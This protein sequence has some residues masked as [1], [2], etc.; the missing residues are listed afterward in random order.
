MQTVIV[1]G[2][3][4]FIGSH[5]LS[6]LQKNYKVF[7]IDKAVGLN[8]LSPAIE[9]CF[10]RL[11]PYAI[12]HLAAESHVDTSIE[13][14]LDCATTNI[15]GTIRL[16]NLCLKYKVKQFIQFSTDE[17]Y[18]DEP[19]AKKED[20]LLRPSN[21]YS[22][23]KAS[24]EHFVRAYGRTYGLPYKIVR[25]CNNYGPN[26]LVE[27]FIPAVIH[28][29]LH[30]K[31]VNLH[32]RGKLKR[33]WI[34]VSDCA[35]AVKVILERGKLG[36]TYNIGTGIERSN[37]YIAR[38]IAWYLDK[39]LRLTYKETRKGVDKQYLMNSDKI[40]KLGWKPEKDFELG[41]ME[42]VHGYLQSTK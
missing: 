18:G 23:S 17:V 36:E 33:E 24:A 5:V 13:S 22:A 39:G 29:I 3:S 35:K 15:L 9:L 16:M 26:Q 4:G 37:G 30:N 2:A 38:R 31:P 20:D 10:K 8:I 21:P 42:T 41:L 28:N 34:H 27:K 11:R 6:L 40:R 14:P 7:N 19:R 12:I 25:A 32:G 1:T